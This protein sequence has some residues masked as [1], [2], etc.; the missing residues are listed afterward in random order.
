M[1]IQ[2]EEYLSCPLCSTGTLIA[3]QTYYSGSP[4]WYA[5]CDNE[6]CIGSEGTEIIGSQDYSFPLAEWAEE[7]GIYIEEW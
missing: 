7:F 4:V 6:D 2:E 5:S 1:T 3:T